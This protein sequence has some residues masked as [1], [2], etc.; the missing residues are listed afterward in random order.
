MGDDAKG[1]L[2]AFYNVTVAEMQ[3]CIHESAC[4]ASVADAPGAFSFAM[5]RSA[6]GPEV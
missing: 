2:H 4:P 5:V 3:G 6:G 1:Y